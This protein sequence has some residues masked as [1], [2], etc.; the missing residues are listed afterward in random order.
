M[1]YQSDDQ[2]KARLLHQNHHEFDVLAAALRSDAYQ[3]VFIQAPTAGAANGLG[4]NTGQAYIRYGTGRDAVYDSIAIDISHP[5]EDTVAGPRERLTIPHGELFGRWFASPTG[6]VELQLPARIAQIT[7]RLLA[8]GQRRYEDAVEVA[9]DRDIEYRRMEMEREADRD[10]EG[11][12][13][14]RGNNFPL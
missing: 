14:G 2:I 10:P 9:R 5:W 12:F 1:F 4:Y 13:G 3:I 11:C 7:A 8:S 6:I